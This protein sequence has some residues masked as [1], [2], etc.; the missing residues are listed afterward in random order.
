LDFVG[1][2]MPAV[3]AGRIVVAPVTDLNDAI[4]GFTTYAE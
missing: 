3:A 2:S 4:V 1:A